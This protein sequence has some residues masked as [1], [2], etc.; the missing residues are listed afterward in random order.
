ME[1]ANVIIFIL[2]TLPYVFNLAEVH[3]NRTHHGHFCPSLDLK[4]RRPT[5]TFPLPK[6]NLKDFLFKVNIGAFIIS[7]HNFAISANK[8]GHEDFS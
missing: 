5:R 6:Y 1:K 7:D 3:G 4:S 8:N 2:C